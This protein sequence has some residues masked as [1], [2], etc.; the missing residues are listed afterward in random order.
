MLYFAKI[1][2][3][4]VKILFCSSSKIVHDGQMGT[5]LRYKWSL[6]AGITQV[7]TGKQMLEQFVVKYS[8]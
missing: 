6:S 2:M 8:N 4:M 1:I 7:M 3:D 5:V